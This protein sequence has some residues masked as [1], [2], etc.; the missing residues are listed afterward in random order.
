MKAIEPRPSPGTAR[1]KSS[2]KPTQRYFDSDSDSDNEFS[3]YYSSDDSDGDDDNDSYSWNSGNGCPTISSIIGSSISS[4]CKNGKLCINGQEI[5]NV[6]S[7][8]RIDI[9]A[10][11]LQINGKS[12][13]RIPPSGN[14]NSVIIGNINM[15]NFGKGYSCP[16]VTQIGCVGISHYCIN[17]QFYV[18]GEKISNVKSTD[19]VEIIS[20]TLKIN[21][22]SICCDFYR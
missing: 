18:N 10:N 14:N 1:R 3:L 5:K 4:T 22:K 19:R 9:I 6:K 7:T 11:E 2:A 13:R 21:G 16:G 20:N 12:I 17:G 8:D 15:G